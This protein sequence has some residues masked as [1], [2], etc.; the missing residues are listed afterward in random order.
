MKSRRLRGNS[1][2][3]YT[4]VEA[5]YNLH[6]PQIPLSAIPRVRRSLFVFTRRV[7]FSFVFTLKCFFTFF[8]RH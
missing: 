3:K 8:V 5:G 2:A 6:V 4:K 7:L 1:V